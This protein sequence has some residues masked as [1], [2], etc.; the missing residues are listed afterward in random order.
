MIKDRL[1]QFRS[2]YWP[3]L[4]LLAAT[5]A[6]YGRI[7]EHEFLVNWDDALYVTNNGA[8]LSLSWTNIRTIF[9]SYYAGNY[10][11]VQM[12]SYM[13]DYQIWGLWPGGY[14]VTNI[15]LHAL[16]GLLVYRLFLKLHNERLLATIG[17]AIFLLHPLQVESVAWISQRKNLLAMLFFLLAWEGYRHYREAEEGS[18][19]TAYAVALAGFVLALLAKSVVVIFPVVMVLYDYCFAVVRHRRYILEKVPFVIAA[20]GMA[21]VALLSQTFDN[22]VLGEG[23]GTAIGYHGGS[24]L[25]TFFTMLHIFCRYLWMLVWPVQLSHNYDPTIHQSV[26]AVV[27]GSAM[28][29][30]VIIFL[31]VWLFRCDRR[32]GFW[33]I[34]YFVGLLPV[35]QVIPLVTLMND[36][37]LYF[38]ILG[39]AALAGAGAIWMRERLPRQQRVWLYA[40]LALALVLLSVGSFQRAAVWQNSQTLWRDA[41]AK[42]PAKSLVWEGY[43]EACNF[44]APIDKNEALRAYNRALELDPDSELTLYNL[45]VLYVDL[46]DYVMGSKTLQ[47]LLDRNPKYVMGWTAL[48]D[49]YVRRQN[50]ESAGKAYQ[51]AQLLQ[52]E[53]VQVLSRLGEL[54]AVEGRLDAARLYYGRIESQR[55]DNPFI[56]YQLARI[57]AQSGQMDTALLWLERSLQRGY[58]DFGALMADEELAPLRADGRFEN[59]LQRYFPRQ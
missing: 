23:G 47:K 36:R 10:A 37:Y 29:L 31:S 34:Y 40:L 57:E 21:A 39:V 6:V 38:P 24:A 55:G 32:L 22:G 35:S 27:A 9:T 45:G 15:F 7:I 2:C 18:G 20:G 12:L 16:N 26:D 54:A 44:S 46:G 30:A 41:V 3:V 56:A 52:P 13:F 5:C 1:T 59:L 8:L 33:P 42:S 53:A 28:L 4:L 17:A 50:Y 19:G 14:L 58:R 48:G 51:Q 11:P 49:M 43:A 25:A